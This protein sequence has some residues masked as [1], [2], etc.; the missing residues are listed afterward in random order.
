MVTQK[1]AQKLGLDY[2]LSQAR[3]LSEGEWLTA[4]FGI[5]PEKYVD[6]F[7]N[8]V[9]TLGF[10]VGRRYQG[11]TVNDFFYSRM[12]LLC[13]LDE[14]GLYKPKNSHDNLTMCLVAEVLSKRH[15]G[16]PKGPIWTFKQLLE[17]CRGAN[18]HP[19]DVIFYAYITGPLWLRALASL[20]M[21]IVAASIILASLSK[22]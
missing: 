20:G 1:E 8:V 16:V 2:K 9:Y 18:W 15:W 10:E 19:K 22:G 14:N 7:N 5:S 13:N 17:A 12:H 4:D 3:F 11:Y 6:S 21:P